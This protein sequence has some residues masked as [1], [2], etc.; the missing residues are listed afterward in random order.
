MILIK[1]VPASRWFPYHL[2]KA[3]KVIFLP[4]DRA[5]RFSFISTSSQ[6]P[7]LS[8]SLPL[9]YFPSRISAQIAQPSSPFF[10]RHRSHSFLDSSPSFSLTTRKNFLAKKNMKHLPRKSTRRRN[11]RNA[12]KRR[13]RKRKRRKRKRKSI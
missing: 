4:V 12:G 2:E 9:S 5:R 13:K 10:I 3:F 6:F 1:P 8:L 11:E 7:P